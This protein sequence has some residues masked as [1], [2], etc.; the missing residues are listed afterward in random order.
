[1]CHQI[2]KKQ[3][4]TSEM[5]TWKCI[6]SSQRM[7][8]STEQ[9]SFPSEGPGNWLVLHFLAGGTTDWWPLWL[10]CINGLQSIAMPPDMRESLPWNAV[11]YYGSLSIIYGAAQSNFQLM[12]IKRYIMMSKMDIGESLNLSCEHCHELICLYNHDMQSQLLLHWGWKPRGKLKNLTL[13]LSIPSKVTSAHSRTF[14][15]FS[16]DFHFLDFEPPSVRCN[17][18]HSLASL[19][20]TALQSS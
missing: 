17:T 16:S 13:Q 20:R 10:D 14:G 2:D 3:V 6:V 12:R 18:Y 1:M 9:R 5:A 15:T 11:M 7:V 4:W 8:L 19:P